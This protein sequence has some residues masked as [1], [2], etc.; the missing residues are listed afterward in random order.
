MPAPITGLYTSLLA[1]LIVYLATRV[2]LARK[3]NKIGIGDNGNQ[4]LIVAIR[5][6]ANAIE[7]IPLA[8]LL[9]LM[10]ELNGLS[11]VYL[12]IAGVVLVVSRLAHA[13]GFVKTKGLYSPG[14]FYGT[15]ANWVLV[16]LL[17][18]TNIILFC[19]S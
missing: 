11:A 8:L 19:M 12:H 5:A 2:A 13:H 4:E 9:L 18:I 1:L 16:L 15:L 7:N 14:R 3:S 17:S 6:H 10:A